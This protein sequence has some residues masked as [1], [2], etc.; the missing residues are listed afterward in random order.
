MLRRLTALFAIIMLLAGRAA[1]AEAVVDD[2]VNYE[3]S[4]YVM[5][6]TVRA[7]GDVRVREEL[8]YTNPSAY[9][10]FEQRVDLSGTQG[11]EDIEVWT[12]GHA[13]NQSDDIASDGLDP[14]N[15]GDEPYIM[16]VADDAPIGTWRADITGDSALL[17]IDS[18][19][20][21]DWRTFVFAY[22]LK[23]LCRRGADTALLDR[24]LIPAGRAVRYQSAAA[25]IVMP[26]SDGEISLW[27]EGPLSDEQKLIQYDTISLGPTDIA[28]DESLSIEV[29]FPEAWL[30]EAPVDQ[31]VPPRQQIVDEH[32][33]EEEIVREQVRTFRAQQYIACA[34][35]VA[36][37]IAAL[38][39]LWRRYGRIGSGRRKLPDVRTDAYPVALISYAAFGEVTANALTGTLCELSQRGD[40][41]VT[42]QGGKVSFTQEPTARE[43]GGHRGAAVALL[44]NGD[45]DQMDCRGDYGRAKAFEKLYAAYK[46]AV[47]NDA[48]GAGLIWRN[49]HVLTT[50]NA[51]CLVLGF[52]L[53]GML[54]LVGKVLL[55][56]AVILFL[57]MMA[58]IRL[59]AQVRKL[60]DTGEAL[61]NAARAEV[62]SDLE[63]KPP[64][65]L[66][67]ALRGDHAED[68]DA[69]ELWK[70]VSQTILK[71]HLNN[72]STRPGPRRKR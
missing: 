5:Y 57:F 47:V 45:P 55:V 60:T 56:E 28:P 4:N 62:S 25:V 61:V 22:T 27:T 40:L 71:A 3:I 11:I 31:A 50:V 42:E 58:M 32:D 46:A 8:I 6:L 10:G 9:T 2:T 26:R 38:L 66:A 30:G 14:L 13:L 19:G 36:A 65:A 7:N 18:P 69:L 63:K 24:V 70:G 54:L 33:A 68:Q 23:G 53:M 52:M 29:I 37:C 43:L 21:S 49:E 20:D 59:L 44:R 48:H 67:V 35:Y 41:T 12:D 17:R 16:D 15:S 72:A 39:L 64:V 34:V 1:A 51:F